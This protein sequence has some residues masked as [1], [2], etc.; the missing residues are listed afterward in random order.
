MRLPC[1]YVNGAFCGLFVFAKRAKFTLQPDRQLRA[2]ALPDVRA[3]LR[4]I[5]AGAVSF[6][7][8]LPV[9]VDYK[10][11]LVLLIYQQVDGR[12]APTPMIRRPLRSSRASECAFQLFVAFLFLI[13]YYC[14]CGVL[15]RV[16]R[17]RAG[18]PICQTEGRPSTISLL[19]PAQLLRQRCQV[20]LSLIR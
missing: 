20:K 7:S 12:S 4:C 8:C 11:V 2:T 19:F 15:T 3:I 5:R 16:A 10:C 14:D 18:D 17:S 9:H 13:I 6:G 1:C